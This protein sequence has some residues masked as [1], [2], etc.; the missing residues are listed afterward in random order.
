MVPK[1]A[2]LARRWSPF[3]HS[4]V[5]RRVRRPR[6]AKALEAK[7]RQGFRHCHGR[8]WLWRIAAKFDQAR[9]SRA[10]RTSGARI[11]A[12]RRRRVWFRRSLL[13]A[14]AVDPHSRNVL[15]AGER[16]PRAATGLERNRRQGL[17][18]CHARTWLWPIVAQFDLA[19]PAPAQSSSGA[20]GGLS[21]VPRQDLKPWNH[22]RC[23]ST[24][25]NGNHPSAR[26]EGTRRNC[27]RSASATP[28]TGRAQNPVTLCPSRPGDE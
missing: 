20:G 15:V 10:S 13:R 2:D 27:A 23:C 9:L 8:T 19:R 25:S 18:H 4:A 21:P 1:R 14:A 17:L 6:A 16:R 3:V 5:S 12:G 11:A 22:H 24:A 28:V 7:R 26:A